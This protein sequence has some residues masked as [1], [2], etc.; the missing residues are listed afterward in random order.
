[1][2][3]GEV[4]EILSKRFRAVPIIL[5]KLKEV[6]RGKIYYLVDRL[7]GL[8]GIYIGSYAHQWTIAEWR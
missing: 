3:I 4:L 7:T 6:Y 8:V 1:M 2:T 5:S